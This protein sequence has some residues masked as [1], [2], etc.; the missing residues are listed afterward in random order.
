[1]IRLLLA[2]ALGLAALATSAVPAELPVAPEPRE[3]PRFK[4]VPDL[5]VVVEKNVLYDTIDGQKLYLDVAMP[6]DGGPHPCVV[7]F[8]GG[9]WIGGHRRDLSAG[10]YTKDGKYVS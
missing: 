10:G 4:P 7:M 5:P 1:M 2:T 8:H 6:K 3:V 9:A